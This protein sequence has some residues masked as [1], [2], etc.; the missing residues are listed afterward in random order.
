MNPMVGKI[1]SRGCPQEG[2]VH[3]ILKYDSFSWQEE[4]KEETL[5]LRVTPGHFY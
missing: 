5:C 1:L 4:V 3:T 2:L